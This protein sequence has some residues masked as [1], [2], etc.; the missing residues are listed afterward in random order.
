MSTQSLFV[1]HLREPSSWKEART[2]YR[3]VALVLH[4]DK[5]GNEE[6]FKRLLNE[7]E[8]WKCYFQN[9]DSNRKP[10]TA[11]RTRWSSTSAEGADPQ[12]MNQMFQ[13]FAEFLARFRSHFIKRA[14]ASL[15]LML[16]KDLFRHPSDRYEKYAKHPPKNHQERA[17]W[18][19]ES[20]QIHIWLFDVAYAWLR[21]P[22]GIYF[23]LEKGSNALNQIACFVGSGVQC[24]QR[25]SWLYCTPKRRRD[26]ALYNTLSA[27][28][29]EKKNMDYDSIPLVNVTSFW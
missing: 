7:F 9:P 19:R 18:A 12:S 2:I 22:I 26:Q 13:R 21:R 4:P 15:S 25:L 27:L 17:E 24:A 20:L 23:R 8:E 14:R 11:A 6:E 16:H 10:G 29:W 5:G 3:K 28:Y 1:K